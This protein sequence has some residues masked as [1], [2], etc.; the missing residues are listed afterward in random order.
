MDSHSPDKQD[1]TLDKYLQ[2]LYSSSAYIGL[3]IANRSV[4]QLNKARI[5]QG[6]VS[7][8][9]LGNSF[10]PMGPK[11]KKSILPAFTVAQQQCSQCNMAALPTEQIQLHS[12]QT[13]Q[14]RLKSFIQGSTLLKIISLFSISG[15]RFFKP[16]C[17]WSWEFKGA[18][19]KKT[20][21]SL[22]LQSWTHKAVQLIW[23]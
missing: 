8:S 2:A 13:G 20:D 11:G 21:K 7:A 4:E 18:K 12:E 10:V 16:L 22:L 23:I 17:C 5:S 6:Y 19:A 15:A 1:L 14:K 3:P 9:L